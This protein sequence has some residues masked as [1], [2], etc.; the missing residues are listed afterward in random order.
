MATT[1]KLGVRLMATN[2]VSKEVVFNE[3][4]IVFDTMVSRTALARQNAVP[5]SPEPGACYIVGPDPVGAWQGREN[6]IA[7]FFNGWRFYAPTQKMKFFLQ[8]TSTF[9]TYSGTAWT[10]DPAGT[11]ATLD[12]LT[13]V[14]GS[15]PEDGQVL[16]YREDSGLWEPGTLP[17]QSPL[18]DLPDVD[19]TELVDGQL[20]AWDAQS[21]RWK[22]I[23]PPSGGGGASRLSELDDVEMPNNP[24]NGHFLRWDSGKARFM[25]FTLPSMELKDLTDVVTSGAQANDVLAW[26]GAAWGPSPAVIT[27]SF[28]G[29]VD[30]PQTF[31][32]YAN[33]FLVVD[34]TESQMEFRSLQSLIDSLG[35]FRMADLTDLEAAADEHVGKVITLAKPQGEYRYTY[36][37]LPSWAVVFRTGE[38]DVTDRVR[39]LT[40]NG[41]EVA[42]PEEGHV[43]VTAQNALEFL[44]ENEPVEELVSAIN[45]MGNGV[46][47][48]LIEGVLTV[49]FETPPPVVNLGSLEDVDLESVTPV[50]GHVLR[51][52][53]VT[54]KWVPGEGGFGGGIVDGEVEPA[55]YELGPF[56]PPNAAM[57]PLRHNAPAA[58]LTLIKNRGLFVQPGP[59]GTGVRHAVVARNVG[60]Q[61]VPW[62]LTARVIPSS[63]QVAGHAA[64]IVLQRTFNNS[65]VFLTLGNSNSDTQFALRLGW[66]S[67]TGSETILLTEPNFYPWLRLAFD[68][69]SIRAYV[70]AEGLIWHPFGNPVTATTTLQGAP[71][72]V[73]ITNRSNAAH[74]GNVGALVTYWDDPEFPAAARVQQGVVALGLGGLMDVDFETTPP[75]EGQTVVYSE[76]D[77]KWVPGEGGGGSADYPDMEGNAHGLLTVDQEEQGVVW[78][79]LKELV[80]GAG[81]EPQLVMAELVQ[82]GYK[83]I[84]STDFATTMPML[85]TPGNWLVAYTAVQTGLPV[86]AAGWTVALSDG[87]GSRM[88]GV[89]AYKRVEPGDGLVL[90][91]F[92]NS[93]DF[94]WNTIFEVKSGADTWADLVE[95]V[96]LRSDAAFTSPW[97]EAVGPVPEQSLALISCLVRPSNTSLDLGPDWSMLVRLVTSAQASNRDLLVGT[98]TDAAEKNLNVNLSGGVGI[99]HAG[100]ALIT[101][102]PYMAMVQAGGVMLSD[103]ADVSPNQPVDGNALLWDDE[104]KAWKPGQAGTLI[105]KLEDIGDVEFPDLPVDGN[106]LIY[107]ATLGKWVPGAGF[108]NIATEFD[109]ALFITGTPDP[110]AV[111]VRYITAREYKLEV[112]LPLSFAHA[113]TPPDAPI[114]FSIQKNGVEIGKITFGYGENDGVFTFENAVP[115]NP[116]DRLSVVSPL[117]L[118]NIEDISITFAGSRL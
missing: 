39:S 69:D 41:F 32:G 103:L 116:G 35:D 89:V 80:A 73:G 36:T 71:D 21:G 6:Q 93:F 83:E 63:F 107:D 68:G 82:T 30:G 102:K 23:M 15:A 54:Q 47:I 90:T 50:D 117:S 16:T 11:P 97:V 10:Q 106:S 40:F 105:E 29:M 104:A 109:I 79:Q 114:E 111:A 22:N 1:P 25:G 67:P 51:Y 70:S 72:R 95:G 55:L 4:A 7:L 62:V 88:R 76:A 18:S 87:T 9:W 81:V 84:V 101:F 42:E 49:D 85:P 115:F 13:N 28:L 108:G 56:A 2:D 64:G 99:E 34:P 65:F 94:A 58:D 59:Q 66:V 46:N 98:N 45:F 43:V 113:D 112:D 31:D 12:D 92:Q 53:G 118:Q 57:F 44:A 24:T 5:P 48:T 27:Y 17:S 75:T 110:D 52:D 61:D 86:A 100:F 8:S 96:V 3:A 14:G 91:P 60:E 20:I 33:H 77:Q 74:T 38:G 78:R 37:A 19:F 26:N